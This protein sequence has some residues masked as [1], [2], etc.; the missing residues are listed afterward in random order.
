[1]GLNPFSSDDSTCKGRYGKVKDQDGNTT[2]G[3][4]MKCPGHDSDRVV[5]TG[6]K[7]EAQRKAKDFLEEN[8][9]SAKIRD[10]S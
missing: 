7:E 1:M 9:Y 6:D 3:I 8:D 10:D 2:R 5:V 4:E